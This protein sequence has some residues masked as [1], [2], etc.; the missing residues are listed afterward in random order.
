MLTKDAIQEL[1]QA[2]AITAA[3]EHTVNTDALVLPSNFAVHDLEKFSACRRRARGTMKTSS[4][5]DFA[6]Y[7]RDHREDGASVFVN[8]L[9]ATAVL[10]MGTP[11]LPGHCDNRAVIEPTITAAYAALS[12][13]ASG[14]AVKQATAAEF[15]EDWSEC[16]QAF[17]EE[18]PMPVPKAVSALRRITIEGVR[19]IEAAEQ[20]LSASKSTFESVHASSGGDAVPT[21]LLFTCIPYVG[22]DTRVFIVRIG[23]QTGGDKPM[24]VFRIANIESAD[25]DM[26]DEFCKKLDSAID[27]AEDD[28]D[29]AVP[30]LIGSYS[31]GL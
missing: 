31:A 24:L 13:I 25:E 14:G 6:A 27:A 26:A 2:Q 17:S 18:D 7:V 30:V 29:T 10:N 12:K 4:I 23:V 5:D 1:S 20:A 9:H 19:K 28:T 16:I 21:R 22:F 8:G 11:E 15:L 3:N